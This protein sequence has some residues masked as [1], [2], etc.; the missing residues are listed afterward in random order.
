MPGTIQ[1]RDA[2]SSLKCAHSVYAFVGHYESLPKT[3][4]ALNVISE[5]LQNEAGW[6]LAVKLLEQWRTANG[7]EWPARPSFRATGLRRSTVGDKQQFSSTEAAA[8]AGAAAGSVLGW[9]VSMKAFH[10]ELV[11]WVSCPCL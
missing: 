4:D 7:Y 6:H 11:I 8:T 9:T 1:G 3:K 5:R 10:A 2:V